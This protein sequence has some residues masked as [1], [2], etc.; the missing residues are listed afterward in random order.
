M[1]ERLSL[2]EQLLDIEAI[3]VAVL[4]ELA[5]STVEGIHHAGLASDQNDA[6]QQIDDALRLDQQLVDLFCVEVHLL[7][8]RVH[9]NGN[10]TCC[11]KKHGYQVVLPNEL[12]AKH[13][14]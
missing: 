4:L 6:E 1:R 12:L 8:V 14:Y 2:T 5:Q 3:V 11:D 13:M 10:R 7:C 9:H